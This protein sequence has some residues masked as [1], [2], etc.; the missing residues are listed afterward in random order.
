MEAH[1]P[2]AKQCTF[3]TSSLPVDV[4]QSLSGVLE[5]ALSDP[6]IL[7][8]GE[9]IYAVRN[10]HPFA[11]ANARVQTLLLHRELTL[12]GYHPVSLLHQLVQWK[13]PCHVRREILR[14]LAAW[15]FAR[16]NGKS[17]WGNGESKWPTWH[18]F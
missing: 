16:K 9:M 6:R 5:R 10:S 11:D 1:A 13:D 15:A 4:G 14:G 18:V 12:L 2:L 3:D 8:V 17:A 7:C